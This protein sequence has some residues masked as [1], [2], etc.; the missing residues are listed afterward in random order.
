MGRQKRASFGAT[1]GQLLI[2]IANI[3]GNVKISTV[4]NRRYQ[5]HVRSYKALMNFGPLTKRFRALVFTEAKS[6]FRY[7]VNYYNRRL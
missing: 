4:G 6:I 2:S 5:L 1:S 7:T 3:S